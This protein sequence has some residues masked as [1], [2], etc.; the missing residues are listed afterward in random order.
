MC[1]DKDKR[2]ALNVSKRLALN[3]SIILVGTWYSLFQYV[4]SFTWKHCYLYQHV[5]TFILTDCSG[6]ADTTASDPDHVGCGGVVCMPHRA[7]HGEC[8]TGTRISKSD[9][10]EQA[11][12]I[13][14]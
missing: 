4:D 9:A 13:L 10:Y 7:G 5:N 1:S 2:S 14:P 8:S 11:P 3:V 6:C 12:H